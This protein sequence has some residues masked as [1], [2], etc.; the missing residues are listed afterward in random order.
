MNI[1]FYI[2]HPLL[3]QLVSYFMTFEAKMDAGTASTVCPF[4]PTPQHCIYFYVN[5]PVQTQKA[6]TPHFITKPP[7][8]TVGP[9]LTRVNIDIG[10]NHKMLCVAFHPAGLY[11]LLGTPMH[12]LFDE[13]YDSSLLLGN[14][15]GQLNQQLKEAVNPLQLKILVENFLLKKIQAAK[16]TLPFD[17]AMQELVK[18]DGNTPIEKIA[19]LS[20]LSLRQFER[21][22]KERIGIPP[23]LFARLTRFSKAYRLKESQ[24]GLSWTSIAYECGYFDQMHLIRDF[25]EFAGTTPTIMQHEII[26]SPL[27]LQC[28]HNW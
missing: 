13:D 27:R 16:K 6:G 21:T 8:I 9:Q 12:Q 7:S 15:I 26:A 19:A 23:K 17:L 3:Q 5:D 28:N 11:R 20:C 10:R 24:T 22:C 14:G 18:T 2:P 25:K 1:Q 4:P